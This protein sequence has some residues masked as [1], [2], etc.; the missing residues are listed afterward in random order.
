M[1]TLRKIWQWLCRFVDDSWRILK[2]EVNERRKDI[3]S[4]T[5]VEIKQMAKAEGKHLFLGGLTAF[6]KRQFPKLPYKNVVK[7]G[8]ED[9]FEATGVQ[10]LAASGRFLKSFLSRL[11]GNYSCS[12][13]VQLDFNCI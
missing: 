5:T 12:P 11:T 6:A 3:A 7:V 9:C 13:L 8:Y 4:I 10:P 1:N 2:R